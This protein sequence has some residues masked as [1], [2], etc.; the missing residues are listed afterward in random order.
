[1]VMGGL[2]QETKA[3]TSNGLPLLSRIPIIGGL[4]GTQKLVNNRNELIMFITPRVVES[5][6]DLRGIVDDL[7][8]RMEKIDDTFPMSS[9]ARSSTPACWTGAEKTPPIE[10]PFSPPS[11]LPQQSRQLTDSFVDRLHRRQENVAKP[12]QILLQS[13]NGNLRPMISQK[14]R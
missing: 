5:E 13:Y 11:P 14:P 9:S 10:S 8:H 7:R 2:I 6:L 4:F 1:M 3:N 12:R